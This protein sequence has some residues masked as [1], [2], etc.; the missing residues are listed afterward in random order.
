MKPILLFGGSGSVRVRVHFSPACKYGKFF[1][2][3]GTVQGVDMV[4]GFGIEG[5]GNLELP[6]RKR[7]L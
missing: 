1:R 4:P 2:L 7:C 6:A 3:L 5:V